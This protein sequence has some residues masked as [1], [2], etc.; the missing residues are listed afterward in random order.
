MAR[1]GP[2]AAIDAMASWSTADRLWQAMAARVDGLDPLPR[3]GVRCG[4][5][6]AATAVNIGVQVL[7]DA[8]ARD[9]AHQWVDASAAALAPLPVIPYRWGRVWAPYKRAALD[10]GYAAGMAALKAWADPHG[11]LPSGSGVFP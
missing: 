6:P 9:Q 2:L 8:T 7:A 3:M 11:V 10:A 5:Y 1:M 4:L